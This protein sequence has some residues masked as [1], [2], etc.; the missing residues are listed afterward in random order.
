M[1]D[2]AQRNGLSIDATLTAFLE[3]DALP[4]SGVEPD[5]FW[6][7]L[8]SIVAEFGPQNRA[9][10]AKRDVLQGKIDA[11]HQ[12]RAGQPH[13]ATAYDTFLREIGYLID[14][15]PAFEVETAN[16]DPEMA[17]LP[18]PQLVV[19]VMNARYA[20]N[21][22][23]ARWGSLYDALYGTD[24]LGDLPQKGGFDA[25]RGA[26]VIAW[27][28]AHLDTV[29]PLTAA[30]WGDVTALSVTDGELAVST[31]TGQTSLRDAAQFV[32]TTGEGGALSSVLLSK[33]GLGLQIIIDR[34][35]AIG[36]A[37]PAGIA[38]VRLESAVWPIA[39]GWG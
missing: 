16:V 30:L 18:G 20:I 19:P 33:H 15:G 31:S 7:G 2:M 5:T 36:A 24:A 17:L 27:A 25:A 8:A 35:S 9:L 28:R 4:G 21:A 3:A 32:G 1:S 6:A 39:T 29:A 38:D 26:R 34:D 10:V 13:D 22:A 12:A 37:D 14:T 11:W 23:N